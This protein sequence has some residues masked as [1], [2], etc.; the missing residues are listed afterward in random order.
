[1]IRHANSASSA[2]WSK[3]PNMACLRLGMQNA[4]HGLQSAVLRTASIFY[5]QVDFRVSGDWVTGPR[6]H[7][8]SSWLLA[9]HYG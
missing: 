3:L 9:Q 7:Q 8:I 1:M 2:K 6:G 4:L 5:L